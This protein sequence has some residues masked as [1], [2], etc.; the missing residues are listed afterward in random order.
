MRPTMAAP[1]HRELIVGGETAPAFA[2]PFV[3]SLLDDHY[4]SCGASL[5]SMR[6]ALTAAHCIDRGNSRYS[7]AV[8]RHQL[9]D[10]DEHECAEHIEVEAAHCHPGYSDD[11]MQNDICLLQL[12]R[13]PHCSDRIPTVALDDGSYSEPGAYATVAGWGTTEADD[14][15]WDLL[16][17]FT[18]DY[19][20][21]SHS[22]QLQHVEVEVIDR[23][24]CA[25]QLESKVAF[26]VTST[27]LCA[28]ARSGGK[29]S[30]QG[31]SGGALFIPAGPNQLRPIQIG[32]VS[33]G[34]GCGAPRSPGVY[35]RVSAYTDWIGG[36]IELPP[37]MPPS[38]PAPPPKPPLP[39]LPPLP[40]SPPAAPPPRPPRPPSPPSPPTPPIAPQALA[41]TCAP[42]G[43]SGGAH[44]GI[45]GCDDHHNEQGGAWCYVVEP[46]ECAEA[47]PS[48]RFGGA[49]FVEC[50]I[51]CSANERRWAGEWAHDT[52]DDPNSVAVFAT[53]QL[54]VTNP[55]RHWSP[56][57]GTVSGS[58]LRMD[59]GGEE[60]VGQL[61]GETL[62]WENGHS[63]SRSVPLRACMPPPPPPPP[64]P[65][66]QPRRCTDDPSYSE[67]EWICSDWV[68]YDCSE[69]FCA[70]LGGCLDVTLLLHSCPESCESLHQGCTPPSSATS[71]SP[72]PQVPP[73][74]MPLPPAPLSPVPPPPA[75][76]PP[77]PPPPHNVEEGLSVVSVRPYPGYTGGLSVSGAVSFAGDAAGTSHAFTWDLAGLDTA[78]VAGFSG[79]ANACG[80]HLHSDTTC[81]DASQVGGDPWS[82]IEYVSDAS[83]SSAGL[84]DVQIGR[85]SADLRGRAFVVH[86][87]DG[88][89][90]AC[91][92]VQP[93]PPESIASLRA[94]PFSP[95]FP[96]Q[97][98]LPPTLPPAAIPPPLPPLPLASPVA[99]LTLPAEV[100]VVLA[101]SAA[102]A[103]AVFLLVLAM[104]RSRRPGTLLTS[105]G[106]RRSNPPL[107]QGRAAGTRSSTRAHIIVHDGG[108]EQSAAGR[109]QQSSATQPALAATAASAEELELGV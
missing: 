36:I 89:R 13:T 82:T 85:S 72:S 56:A 28:G 33:W 58:T 44:T 104:R 16:G 57:V 64:H 27:M 91:G 81:D 35:T 99:T 83:G 95:P 46:A 94:A 55:V 79:P 32:I 41:C 22:D 1:H 11:H 48:Q 5:I 6:W 21:S 12:A 30:C 7:V 37:P 88:A 80:L 100:P 92:I 43:V 50:T 45:A 47:E 17:W 20:G 49:G 53:S 19:A 67:M 29:D 68:G 62:K 24:I 86:G 34:V 9:S 93:A 39:P 60:V 108:V 87:S 78:C 101:V 105:A 42:D 77:A 38:P 15:P 26:S 98:A 4:L 90:I 3:L 75:P 74:P 23:I 96:P 18:Y 84:S 107:V 10:A 8:H 40:P 66:F 71:Q 109:E 59:F 69:G 73:S 65:P 54:L 52:G 2:F 97:A 70:P 31:D 106:S 61:D 102:A 103:L 63:W 76:P 14:E 51:S 25:A